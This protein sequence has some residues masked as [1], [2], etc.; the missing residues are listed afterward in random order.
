MVRE[1][2]NVTTI[3]IPIYKDFSSKEQNILRNILLLH[4]NFDYTDN[5]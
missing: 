5:L 2:N 3:R 4:L 1:S